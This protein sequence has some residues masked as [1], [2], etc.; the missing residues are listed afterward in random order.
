MPSL[1]TIDINAI[2]QQQSKLASQVI[3][4]NQFKQISTVAGVDVAYNEVADQVVGAI[5]VL[6]ASTLQLIESQTAVE[7]ISFPYIPGLFSFR[8]IPPLLSAYN[9]LSVKPDL[10]VCDGQGIAHPRRFGLACHLGVALDITTIGCGKSKLLGNFAP[11]AQERGS[12]SGLFDQQALI[13]NVLRTQDNIKPI[14]VSIGHKMDLA[15]AT[16]WVLKLASHYR[17]PETTRQADQLVNKTLKGLAIS[18]HE[19]TT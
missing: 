16:Q 10:I 2:E 8:E 7:Q 3:K 4:T 19:L 13:G 1:D 18:A 15:T 9:K 6:D 17:L 11:V 12:V 14:F 5:T